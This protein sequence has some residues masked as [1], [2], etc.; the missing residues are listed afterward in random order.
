MFA[1]D[2]VL[3]D[4]NRYKHLSCLSLSHSFFSLTPSP[5]LLILASYFLALPRQKITS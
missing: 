5:S 2:A 1:L 4:Y 3:F